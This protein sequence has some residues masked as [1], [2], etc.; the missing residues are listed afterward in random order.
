MIILGLAVATCEH[1]AAALVVDGAVV[2]AAEEE[3]FNGVKHY[4]WHP[5]GQPGANLVNSPDL[6]INDA[7]C[8]GVVRWLLERQDLQLEDVDVIA[9]N[10]IPHRF[11]GSRDNFRPTL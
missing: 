3:R 10:G 5:P 1:H 8:R 9:V 2:G 4:G 6:T 7:L 11:T